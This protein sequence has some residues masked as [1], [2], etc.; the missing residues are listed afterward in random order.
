MQ[1]LTNNTQ[2]IVSTHNTYTH[3]HIGTLKYSYNIYKCQKKPANQK[4]I[5]KLKKIKHIIETAKKKKN[6]NQNQKSKQT[7]TK[8]QNNKNKTKQTNRKKNATIFF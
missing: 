7:K 5:N 6:T 1:S 8:K 4:Q 3:I 2:S